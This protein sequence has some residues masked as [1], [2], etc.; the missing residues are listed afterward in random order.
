M[1]NDLLSTIEYRPLSP[2][3]KVRIQSVLA[4]GNLTV[5]A[6]AK[7]PGMSW[8]KRDTYRQVVLAGLR[9][10]DDCNHAEI[11]ACR[12]ISPQERDAIRA[13][14]EV[15]FRLLEGFVARLVQLVR[16]KLYMA[17][18]FANENAR[19]LKSDLAG[20]AMTAFCHAIY[21]FNRYDLQFNT[22]LTTV[23]NNW[24]TD[25]C[26]KLTTIKLSEDMKELLT[27]YYSIKTEERRKGRHVGFEEITR[28][29]I[30]NQLRDA[31]TAA[32]DRNIE[33][34]MERQRTRF[35]ELRQ[36]IRRNLPVDEALLASKDSDAD[37]ETVLAEVCERMS[38]LEAQ[39][40]RCKVDG[41]TLKELAEEEGVTPHEAGRAFKRAKD[42]I[43][44]A[45][46]LA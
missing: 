20:E 39:A 6:L 13:V 25:Y 11:A 21:R 2:R 23:V 29:I 1:K 15:K 8:D 3:E 40:I 14:E 33:E 7:K 36:V 41:R 46:A 19:T 44:V 31:G 43:G 18:W 30:V 42:K 17:E 4:T 32:T 27:A 37:T 26:E 38:P 16:R 5:E 24:L 9:K 35:L 34:A 22:F 12:A 10:H 28:I 45:L